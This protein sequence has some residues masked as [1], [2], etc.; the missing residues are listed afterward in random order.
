MI[1]NRLKIMIQPI[2]D[3]YG[4]RYIDILVRDRFHIYAWF[5]IYY[6]A[7]YLSDIKNNEYNKN[8]K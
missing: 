5:T 2:R 4:Y 3:Q 1:T 7:V 8:N 6:H